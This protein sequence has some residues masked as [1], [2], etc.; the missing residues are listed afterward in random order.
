MAK[1]KSSEKSSEVRETEAGST[2]EES[3]EA[4]SPQAGAIVEA[5]TPGY[6]AAEELWLVTEVQAFLSKRGELAEKLAREIEATEKKLAEL[7]R[8]AALLSPAASV[9]A[10]RDKKAKK[11][12]LKKKPERKSEANV[13]H[14]ESPAENH[15]AHESQP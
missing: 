2:V 5:S 11:P 7:K 14:T 9:E 10:A 12:T 13:E 1:K 4:D 6:V 15:S 8:T 3:T